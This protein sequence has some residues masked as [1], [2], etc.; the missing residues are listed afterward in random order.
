MDQGA[1]L[2]HPHE[3]TEVPDR[4][5]PEAGPG[6]PLHH[7]Q[8]HPQKGGVRGRPRHPQKEVLQAQGRGHHRAG[9]RRLHLLQRRRRVRQEAEL[10]GT[11]RQDPDPGIRDQGDPCPPPHLQRREQRVPHDERR[12]RVLPLHAAQP[13]HRHPRHGPQHREGGTRMPSRHAPHRLRLGQQ[14]DQQHQERQDPLPRH[15]S[16]GG[17]GGQEHH[18]HRRG[19]GG[20]PQ[21]RTLHGGP[22]ARLRQ[23]GRGQRTPVLPRLHRQPPHRVRQRHRRRPRPLPPPAGGLLRQEAVPRQLLRRREQA[24]HLSP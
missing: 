15:L 18:L 16:H 19:P 21:L 22:G 5:V 23:D 9:R 13:P 2:P 20:A 17:E 24:R 12:E 4:G 14:E 8:P 3:E 11:R 7:G 1:D 6:H 10:E